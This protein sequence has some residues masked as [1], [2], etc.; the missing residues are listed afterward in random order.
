MVVLVLAAVATAAAH[1]AFT[2]Y[3]FI[4]N[5][6]GRLAALETASAKADLALMEVAASERGYVAPGQ[7][8]DF[9]T[10]RVD[11][12][13]AEADTALIRL[14]S[15]ATSA[16]AVDQLGSAMSRLDDLAVMDARARQY[17]RDGRVSMASDLI[18]ADGYEMI[19]AARTEAA[20]ATAAER[21]AISTPLSRDSRIHMASIA[22]LA[23]CVVIPLLLLLRAPKTPEPIMVTSI[24]P[25]PIIAPAPV[26]VADDAIGAALDA[27]LEGLDD[28]A[29]ALP[30]ESASPAPA[31]VLS[32][33]A[34]AAMPASVNLTKAADVCVDLARLLDARDL[35]AVLA[36]IAAVLDANGLI[37]WMTDA[38]GQ[39]LAPAV[40]HGYA[41]ALMARL[42]A[43]HVD[44][45]NATADAWRSK[46]MQVVA[47]SGNHPGALAVPLLTSGGCAGVL[48]V[49]LKDGK[50]RASD[51]QSLARIVGAQLAAGI[52]P[53][54]AESRR[55]AE[56]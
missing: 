40:T 31:A 3:I 49:E 38:S 17:A 11:E 2:R 1:Q 22:V 47:G 45:D 28:F 39:S 24:E 56:A 26:A 51:V 50:E 6:R 29:P 13:L 8:V 41:P 42:G 5:A 33:A 48:A 20:A 36:R 7:G 44:A 52:S 10:T 43:L 18:F 21:Q 37:V 15:T 23:G 35:Q 55:A 4:E 27:S 25:L 19:A 46:S 14:R 16:A 34:V 53:P 9:W 32:P 12:S 30:V 54:A